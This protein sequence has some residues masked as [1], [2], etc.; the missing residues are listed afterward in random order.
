MF[1]F[2]ARVRAGARS[3]ED[4]PE[5]IVVFDGQEGAADRRTLM[6]GYKPP[7]AGDEEVFADLPLLYKGLE[8]LDIPCAEYPCREA[9]DIIASFI[10]ANPGREH[11]IM[12]TDKDFYQLL[13][14]QVSAL[15]TQRRADRR[16]IDADEVYDTYAVT[17]HQWC[18]YRALTGDKSDNI[19]GVRGIGPKTASRLL[20]DG[21]HLEDLA[22]LDR[23]TGRTGTLI[24]ECW[25]DLLLWRTLIQLRTDIPLPAVTSPGAPTTPF[26]APEIVGELGL[27]N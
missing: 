11:V 16:R 6:P 14:N 26:A 19:P 10:A 12:S 25:D 22:G 13:S 3:L 15:N 2:F 7:V 1:G 24:R 18:D 27:W 21:A 5:I 4:A 23:L 20:A 8:L 17:P 9:D